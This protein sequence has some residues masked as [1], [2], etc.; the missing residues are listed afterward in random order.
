MKINWKVRLKN[1]MFW[2]GIAS[3]FVLTLLAQLGMDFSNITSW[4]S[5]FDALLEAL[6]NPVVVVAV[7]TATCNAVVDPTTAGMSDSK[8]ALQYTKPKEK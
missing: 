3:A 1:P 7:L 8:Q 4:Q 6:R 2:I 5:F